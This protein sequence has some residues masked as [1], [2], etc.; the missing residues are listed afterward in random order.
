MISNIMTLISHS[1]YSYYYHRKFFTILFNF[2]WTSSFTL[3]SN[4][5]KFSVVVAW[6]NLTPSILWKEIR[7]E[8]VNHFGFNLE[9]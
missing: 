5:N 2:R 1:F 3:G 7:D 8:I 6:V 9:R 4:K